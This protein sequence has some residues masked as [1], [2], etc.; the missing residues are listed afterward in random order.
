MMPE[1]LSIGTT[2]YVP[3]IET[4]KIRTPCPDCNDE[5]KWSVSTPGGVLQR[6]IT[7]P[8][9]H[10]GKY[11]YD[12]LL[13][14]RYE[15]TIEIREGKITQ[16]SVR[17]QKSHNS[18]DIHEHIS[19]D[20]A[21]YLGSLSPGKVF[22]SR[23]AAEAAGADMLTADATREQSEWDRDRKRDEVRAGIDIIQALDKRANERANKLDEKIER[24]RDKMLDAIRYPSLYGPK[25]TQKSWGGSELTPQNLAEWLNKLLEEADFETLS[26]EQI[27]EAT[28]D[29]A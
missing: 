15:R 24:L 19:Y 26:E 9:C 6:E 20:T 7:C 13:P 22:V 21:P 27:R 18:D 10:G 23:D 28:C 8:R 11:G 5:G 29:C 25:I 14:V 17:Q 1:T 2:V 3:Q 4:K 12:W 16:V